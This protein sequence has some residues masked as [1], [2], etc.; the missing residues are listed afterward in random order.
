MAL[1]SNFSFLGEHSPL[2][3]LGATAERLFPFDPPSC[4]MRL[5]LL[6]EAL[7]QE[8]ARHIGV[9]SE[10]TQAE[11]LR[12]IDARLNLDR[13]IRDL[14]HLLRKTG[15][16][17]AHELGNRVGHREG[18]EAIKVAREIAVWFHRTFGK[19]PDFQPGPLVMPDDPSRK[20]LELQLQINQLNAQLSE[21]QSAQS[22][23]AE[24]AHLLAAEA[25]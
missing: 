22:Q 6:A 12:A 17:A 13:Q 9:P 15:N 8:V 16:V 23:Q 24:M 1:Q 10:Q 4:V 3:D 2:L 25:A 14:F 21:A 7:A 11:L 5:R 19:Q 18:L 20:L